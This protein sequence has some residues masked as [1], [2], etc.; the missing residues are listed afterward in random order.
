ML[1]NDVCSWLIIDVIFEYFLFPK[2]IYSFIFVYKPAIQVMKIAGD[3]KESVNNAT[4]RVKNLFLAFVSLPFYGFI[5]LKHCLMN[6]AFLR[7]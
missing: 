5:V 7:A 3:T 4:A 6:V 2:V 1:Q